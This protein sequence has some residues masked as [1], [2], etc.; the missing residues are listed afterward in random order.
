MYVNRVL[1]LSD[2]KWYNVKMAV[3]TFSRYTS[4]YVITH[5]TAGCVSPECHGHASPEE[6][7]KAHGGAGLQHLLDDLEHY[8]SK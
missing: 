5:K 1:R 2:G 8:T 3:D 4:R 7:I 6:A